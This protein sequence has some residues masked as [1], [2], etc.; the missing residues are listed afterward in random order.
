[1]GALTNVFSS[2]VGLFQQDI[3]K[4]V[5]YST[6]SQLG[7]MVVA[8]GL[9]SYNI[10]LFHICTHAF[11]KSALFLGAGSII[12]AVADN[13][14]LRRFGGL[15]KFLPLTFSVM[16]IASISLAAFP[17]FSGFY[18]KDLILESA[19][20]QFSFSGT[21]VY[22]ITVIGAVFTMLYSIKILYLTF[23]SPPPPLGSSV[24]YLNSLDTLEGNFFLFFPLVVLALLSIFFGYFTKDLFVGLGT[25]FFTD[26]SIWIHPNHEILIDTEFAVP[27][28]FK[29]L[30]FFF[31]Q[32]FLA[33]LHLLLWSYYRN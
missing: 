23:L 27:H 19:F 15:I 30:P 31:F 12:H 29:L 28:I 32:F 21:A 11:Y 22:T 20:G 1:M 17:F 5:A 10:A 7:L 2:I 6:M 26:N 4:I 16:L 33:F 9:S 18:S 25:G 13:Q 3:K 14:D 8:I 24:N